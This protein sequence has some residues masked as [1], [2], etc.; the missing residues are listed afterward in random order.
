MMACEVRRRWLWT[1]YPGMTLMEQGPGLL[2]P[3]TCSV[4]MYA[5]FYRARI[6]LPDQIN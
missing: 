1:S 4:D 5:A 2:Q 6:A 3:F